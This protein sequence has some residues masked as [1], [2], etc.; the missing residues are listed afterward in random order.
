LWSDGVDGTP[1]VYVNCLSEKDGEAIWRACHGCVCKPFSLVATYDFDFDACLT[2]WPAEGVR[3]GQQPFAGGAEEH[4]RWLLDYVVADVEHKMTG[5]VA[6]S[7]L[8]GYSLA[9]LFALW[10]AWQ[11]ERFCRIGCVSASLWYPHFIEHIKSAK[12]KRMPECVYFSLGDKEKSTR[13]AV[14]GLVGERTAEAVELIEE[15]G[16]ATTFE[17]NRGNH[18]AE[19]AVRMAKAIRWML[20]YGD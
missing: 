12:P 19:P 2:P 18:F 10:T 16:V 15:M 17:T 6:Y 11:T 3:R 13:H 5:N 1:V 4:L 14:M 8:A 7:A 20:E 9:G